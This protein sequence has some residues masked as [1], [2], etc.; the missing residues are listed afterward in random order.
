M[1]EQTRRQLPE[2]FRKALERTEHSAEMLIG[3]GESDARTAAEAAGIA[4]RIAS[5]DCESFPLRLCSWQR[6]SASYPS[7]AAVSRSSLA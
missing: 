3:Q 1:D 7:N 4:V 2:S 6:F 5:R